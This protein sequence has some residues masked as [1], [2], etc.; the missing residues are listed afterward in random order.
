LAAFDTAAIEF[1]ASKVAAVSGDVRKSLQVLRHSI[2]IARRDNSARV[3][4][5]HL[6]GAIKET[7]SSALLPTIRGLCAQE[8]AALVGV[9]LDLKNVQSET[10]SVEAAYARYKSV[11]AGTG[12]PVLAW[13]QFFETLNALSAERLV[14]LSVKN[15]PRLAVVACVA[16][17]QD[18]VQFSLAAHPDFG[19]FLNFAD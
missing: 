14:E 12:V 5:R 13:G 15:T 11:C 16:C 9:C 19:R 2:D 4:L 6:E 10:T 8:M 3:M 17:T 18:D 1:C 7:F